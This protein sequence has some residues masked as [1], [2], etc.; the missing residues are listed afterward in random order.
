VVS[1]MINLSLMWFSGVMPR[2]LH[3]EKPAA[4]NKNGPLRVHTGRC[5]GIARALP[6]LPVSDTQ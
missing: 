4:Q 3:L 2:G 1:K 6:D 5:E